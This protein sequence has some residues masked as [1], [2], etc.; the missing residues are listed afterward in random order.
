V[1]QEPPA[2]GAIERVERGGQAGRI[3]TWETG[4][5]GVKQRRFVVMPDRVGQK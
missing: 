4:F 2:K 3:H 5:L 1:S